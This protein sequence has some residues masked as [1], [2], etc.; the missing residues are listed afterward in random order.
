[1][2]FPDIIAAF[3]A[4]I[5]FLVGFIALSVYY[6]GRNDA[7][8][9][10]ARTIVLELKTAQKYLITA[11]ESIIKDKLIKEDIFVLR[12]NQWEKHKYLFAGDLKSDDIAEINLFYE[13][14]LLYD[15]IVKYNNT[16][17]V[18]NEEQIRS[19]LQSALADYTKGYLAELS[20]ATTA[21]MA[22]NAKKAYEDLIEGFSKEFIK[23]VSSASSYFYQPQKPV[24]DAEAVVH[25]VNMNIMSTAAYKKLQDISSETLRTRIFSW[26]SREKDRI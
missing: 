16:F 15:E 8:K 20:T 3:N 19:N 11:K 21:N 5:T 13:K 22:E 10:A 18:K 14:C 25:T 6:K 4:L 23:Q 24:S 1:M 7:K 12:S 26:L 2:E 17:F 9:D